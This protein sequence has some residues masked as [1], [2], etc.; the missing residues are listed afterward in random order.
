MI[1]LENIRKSFGDN[2][3][4]DG[5]SFDIEKGDVVAIIGPSGTGKSTLLRCIN[6]LE[7]PDEG[8]VIVNGK[9]MQQYVG[10]PG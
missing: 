7:R 1:R 6:M 3:V 4:L 10:D 9:Q 8:S 5:I 2:T